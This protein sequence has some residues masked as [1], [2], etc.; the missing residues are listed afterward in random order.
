M[1]WRWSNSDFKQIIIGLI[2]GISAG[3]AGRLYTQ[4]STICNLCVLSKV[5]HLQQSARLTLIFEFKIKFV[6]IKCKWFQF[7]N[8]EKFATLIINLSLRVNPR[9]RKLM[10]EIGPKTDN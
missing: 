10:V 1:E 8:S 7:N 4:Q 2:V 6:V 9:M 3:L 5:Q